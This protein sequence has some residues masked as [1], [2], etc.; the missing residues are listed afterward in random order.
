MIVY[1][2]L[3][4]LFCLVFSSLVSVDFLSLFWIRD[5]QLS[6]NIP[7]NKQIYRLYVFVSFDP[8]DLILL[9]GPAVTDSDSPFSTLKQY[10]LLLKPAPNHWIN[11]CFFC[12]SSS[13]PLQAVDPGY[14]PFCNLTPMFLLRI[15]DPLYWYK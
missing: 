15:Q 8:R 7:V 2:C 5:P 11:N 13:F 1:R 6:R 10:T 4:A 14:L 3:R 12:F 9:N